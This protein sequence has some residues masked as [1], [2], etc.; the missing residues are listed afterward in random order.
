M[1]RLARYL[2]LSVFLFTA[3]NAHAEDITVFAAASLTNAVTAAAKAYEQQSGDRIEI[4]FASSSTLA[5]Q[6]AA[7]A[8]ADMFI[9]ANQKWMDWL[10]EQDMIEADT[11]NNMV[12]NGL[13][14]IAPNDSAINAISLTKDTDI[15]ALLGNDDRIAVGDPDHVPAGIYAQQALSYLGQWETLAPRLARADNVRA[16]LALVERGEAPLGIVYRTDAAI[17][18][19][20]KIIGTFPDDSHPPITYP[21]ALIKDAGNDSNA[22]FLA[23]LLGDDAGKIFTDYGFDQIQATNT[24]TSK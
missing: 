12:A 14:V 7:G 1:R 18:Q 22:N 5:R 20:V 13:V 3:I 2:A 15:T 24:G 23:W 16:A 21:V 4:S 17:T 10:S 9:S 6:I 8:P 19:G 11:R